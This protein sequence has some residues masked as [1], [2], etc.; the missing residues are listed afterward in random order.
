MGWAGLVR[1]N[2]LGRT[3][4]KSVGPISAQQK[5]SY[6]LL[7]QARPRRHG[8]A[9]IRLAQQPKRAGGIIFPPPLHAERYSFC[10][11]R[12]KK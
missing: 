7:G 9:R 4:P 8:W 12:R 5:N 2:Q 1:P 6:P 10:M 11:Q 3:Q